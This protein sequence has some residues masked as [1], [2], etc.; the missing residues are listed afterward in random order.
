MQRS[1]YPNWFLLPTILIFGFLFVIPTLTSFYYSLTDWNINR[2]VIS[3]IG[4]ENFRELFSDVKFRS[5]LGN[6]L[7]YSFSVTFVRNFLGL[8]L[9][10]LL[11]NAQ[12]KGR[13]LF[14]TIIFLPYVIAP[15]VI[16]YLFTAIYNPAQGI[17][18]QSLR[19][20]GMGFLAQDWLNDP[21]IALFST[22][23]TDV[24]RTT[25]FSMVIYLAGL[26]AIPH[27]LY[28]SAEID[29]ANGRWKLTNVT[30]PLLAP[31]ITINVVLALIGTMKV[32]VMILV[33]TNGGPGYA[34]EVINTYIMSTFSLG[35]YGSGTAA[36]IILSFLIIVI[37][38][39]VLLFL[40]KR[41]VE[42]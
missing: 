28:E 36:N 11:N 8:F 17:L 4:L 32:F 2:R 12:L 16:G 22:I 21:N 33:L 27:E 19:A 25:G 6:T 13:N 40:K 15:V 9:A 34:T 10:I 31:S 26:Q 1:R 41:E 35:L 30:I 3:F 42:L 24:W 29:G 7:T 38:L 18:N 20:F 23:M 5:T 37:A 39:P 14:R